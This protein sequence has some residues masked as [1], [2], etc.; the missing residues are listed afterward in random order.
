MV[1]RDLLIGLAFGS[2]VLL[3]LRVVWLSAVWAGVPPPPPLT[4]AGPLAL[5]VPGPPAPL[6]VL[7]SF[8]SAPLTVPLLY[9][10][11]SFVLLLVLRRQWLA[12]GAVWLFFLALFV[13]PLLGPSPAGNA[14]T[15][16]GY[17]LRVGLQVFVLARFGL[18]A[19]AG[20]SFVNELL[21]LVPL[22]AALSA[23]YPYQ[24]VI[25]ALVVVGLAVYGLVT[26]TRGQ[27]LFGAGFFG[28]E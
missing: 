25:L 7:L 11:L 17:G 15:L 27:R 8:L 26:A 10:A 19:F 24:G 21:S 9:L 22:T 13:V 28:D 6:Y 20:M 4:G 18:L 23:W 3:V 1:G 16:L 14:L 12:W 5:Q 2:A